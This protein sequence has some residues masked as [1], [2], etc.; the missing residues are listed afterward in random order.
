MGEGVHHRKSTWLADLGWKFVHI[1]L[2]LALAAPLFALGY[3]LF[4]WQ[5]I[6]N[7]R[8]PLDKD[9]VAF[10]F[11]FILSGGLVYVLIRP[12]LRSLRLSE[13][14]NVP[15]LYAMAAVLITTIPTVI[16]QSYVA[17][18]SG[19]MT[20]VDN[21]SEIPSVAASKFYSIDTAVCLD[22]RNTHGTLTVQPAG[23][24]NSELEFE[25]YAAVP[26]CADRAGRTPFWIGIEYSETFHNDPWG[27]ANKARYESFVRRSTKML[28]GEDPRLY[29]Y[30]QRVETGQA[31]RNFEKAL[32]KAGVPT[33]PPPTILVPHRERFEQRT[34]NSIR[35][36]LET[37]G[38]G[39]LAWLVLSLLP[40]VDHHKISARETREHSPS[41]VAAFLVPRR[42]AY[43]GA[44]LLDL[45][46]VVFLAM[47]FAG[48]GV[49]SFQVDDLIDWGAS[50]GPLDHG[51]G[52]FRLISSQFVHG[53]L[54]HLA[55]NLYG[56]LFAIIFLLPVAQ[57]MRLILCYLVSGLGG[58]VAS[59]LV[60]PNAV[61]VGASGSIMGLWGTVLILVLLKDRRVAPL[62][63]PILFNVAIFAGLTL[64]LGA[65]DPQVDNA[66][67]IG[68]LI[69]GMLLG[70]LIF[71][72]DH[73]T[74]QEKLS[75]E[76]PATPDP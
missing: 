35:L 19:R 73:S 36:A 45:N 29:R 11:P 17:K 31:Q 57:N 75:A 41:V 23:S 30:F 47:V 55:S 54:M 3:S 5:I 1:F 62:A 65:I 71:L 13:K 70:A 15:F 4:N 6:Q 39:I 21:A 58:A 53:G 50:Y 43:G 74:G 34:G 69:T 2:P 24:N 37:L 10:W 28:D 48:L 16:A 7:L 33:D 38:W 14:R 25:A 72:W 51:V 44:I 22:R 52:L 66:A 26:V 32:R 67:H 12:R 64:L 59:L 63:R 46:I 8:L 68:G 9:L 20:R 60:H 56:L 76:T 42:D 49:A 27:S 61:S 18:A 40:T